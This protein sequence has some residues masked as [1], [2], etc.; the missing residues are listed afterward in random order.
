MASSSGSLPFER[1]DPPN[2]RSRPAAFSEAYWTEDSDV[3]IEHTDPVFEHFELY[4]KTSGNNYTGRCMHCKVLF[5]GLKPGRA[6]AHLGKIKGK[7][8]DFC[9]KVPTSVHGLYKLAPALPCKPATQQQAAQLFGNTEK[10]NSTDAAI[11]DFFY[12]NAIAFNVVDSRS[13]KNMCSKL[14][15]AG[16]TY[17][18]PDRRAL[19]GKLLDEA[20]S[21]TW[22]SVAPVYDSLPTLGGSMLCD[23]CAYST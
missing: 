10:K 5:K 23:G 16:E 3:T 14:N 15:V 17:R 12:D 7:G 6:K 9:H 11:A 2:K 20:E 18:P 19:G 21:R 8:I 1:V 4:E 13:F 22:K